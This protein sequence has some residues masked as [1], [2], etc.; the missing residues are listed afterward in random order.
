MLG[1]L[2]RAQLD[3]RGA[4]LADL[5]RELAKHGIVVS[6]NAPSSWLKGKIPEVDT[7]CAIMEALHVPIG[8]RRQWADAAGYELL[9]DTVIPPRRR[10]AGSA[11]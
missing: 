7:L 10:R 3:L 1:D 11:A 5:R 9:F 8:E 6:H 4:K 2:I